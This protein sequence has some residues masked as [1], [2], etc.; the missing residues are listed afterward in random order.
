GAQLRGDDRAGA[1]RAAPAA[2]DPEGEAGFARWGI[3]PHGAGRCGGSDAGRV[4]GRPPRRDDPPGRCAR[5]VLPA[6]DRDPQQPPGVARRGGGVGGTGRRAGRAADRPGLARREPRH[7]V[8]AAAVAPP[9]RHA[10]LL[11]RPGH[12]RRRRREPPLRLP[13]Q[14]ARA[15]L[16]RAQR[17]RR[18]LRQSRRGSARPGG[19]GRARGDDRCGGYRDGGAAPASGVRDARC[20][21]HRL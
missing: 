9:A 2:E 8:A 11:P 15:P 3:P 6:R 18:V 13:R 14:G 20:R 12:A 5:A 10:P 16:P 19:L 7:A 21:N 4:R 17:H 1:D